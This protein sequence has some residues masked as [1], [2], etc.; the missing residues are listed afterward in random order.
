MNPAFECSVH[1]P[2]KDMIKHIEV[3][4]AP[5][6][7]VDERFRLI[8]QNSLSAGVLELEDNSLIL[9]IIFPAD[10]LMCTKLKF[11]QMARIVFNNGERQH[12]SVSRFKQ[13]FLFMLENNMES[14][15]QSALAIK[16]E[17]DVFVYEAEEFYARMGKDI[18]AK[19]KNIAEVRSTQLSRRLKANKMLDMVT[20]SGIRR[21]G[22]FEPAGITHRVCEAANKFLEKYAIHIYCA[23]NA[24]PYNCIGY[25]DDYRTTI[26][27]LLMI[28]AENSEDGKIYVNNRF[29]EYKYF[30]SVGFPSAVR[31]AVVSD[32]MEERKE[33]LCCVAESNGWLLRFSE[34]DGFCTLLLILP[35]TDERTLFLRAPELVDKDHF[36]VSS[37][38]ANFEP[39]K[40][41]KRK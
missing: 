31:K 19:D 36:A 22:N 9:P 20:G 15:V 2:V 38:F 16:S 3:C 12:A 41:K 5:A 39:P 40:R 18:M 21:S 4:D 34:E 14:F 27:A 32:D 25:H 11:G 37:Q 8:A 1:T 23:A 35:C 29:N 33:Y 30:L 24:S 10:Y 6:F 13:Y 28:A 26:A 17:A 7:I